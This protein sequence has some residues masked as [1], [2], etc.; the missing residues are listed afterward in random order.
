MRKSNIELLRIMC[1]FVI[2][3]QH[4][5]SRDGI[6]ESYKV[7]DFNNNLG[8]FLRC[9]GYPSL[10][11]FVMI[12]GFFLFGRGFRINRILAISIQTLFYAL[13]CLP[14]GFLCNY[15]SLKL[16]AQSVLILLFGDQGYWYV[17]VYIGMCLIIP[18][19][20]PYFVKC[21]KKQYET[22]LFI[23]L[24]MMFIIPTYQGFNGFRENQGVLTFVAVYLAAGYI[25]RFFDDFKESL[26]KWKIAVVFCITWVLS[27]STYP[28]GTFLNLKLFEKTVI[29][30]NNIFALVMGICMFLF[31][32]TC[33]LGSSKVIN[34]ISASTF[35]VYLLHENPIIREL[36]WNRYINREKFYNSPL[37]IVHLMIICISI[38][39]VSIIIDLLLK[40]IYQLVFKSNMYKKICD[41][42]DNK[43]SLT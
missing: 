38:F 7:F 31:F 22:G 2:V 15:F 28:I 19:V 23:I 30:M 43:L 11:A 16:A 34:T 3:V 40:N 12:S 25:R 8:H 6:V 27:Y 4:Y 14:I 20:E 21:S 5:L 32:Y 17:P 39:G 13:L 1:M 26:G 37:F 9:L 29:G 36:L 18:F 33:D 42:I 41:K 10:V 35:A 24:T